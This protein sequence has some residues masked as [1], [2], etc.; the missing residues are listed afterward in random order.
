MIKIQILKLIKYQL[1][2]TPYSNFTNCPGNIFY[3]QRKPQIINCIL[4]SVFLDNAEFP[5]V[6][7][8]HL[9]LSPAMHDNSS[10]ILLFLFEFN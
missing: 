5:S 2:H 6:R 10:S 4:L 1:M 8:E 9:A 7:L 3:R